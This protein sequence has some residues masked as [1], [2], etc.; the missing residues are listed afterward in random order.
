[1]KRRGFLGSLVPLVGGLALML[2]GS[3]PEEKAEVPVLSESAWGRQRQLEGI[4]FEEHARAY[5]PEDHLVGYWPIST[6]ESLLTRED[7]EAA[8]DNPM[9]GFKHFQ[10]GQFGLYEAR[11]M[12][13]EEITQ[14][15]DVKDAPLFPWQYYHDLSEEWDDQVTQALNTETLTFGPIT[16]LDERLE[17]TRLFDAQLSWEKGV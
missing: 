3:A 11:F 16:T 13:E 15:L 2:K 8:R 6:G 4:S 7:I 5:L 9:G 10:E 12:T 1:M 14:S 17:A